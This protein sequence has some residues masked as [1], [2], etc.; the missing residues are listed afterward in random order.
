MFL[1]LVKYKMSQTFNSDIICDNCFSDS[2][3][4]YDHSQGIVV[5]ENCGFISVN[6]FIEQ[7]PE[8]RVYS[9]ENS[10]SNINPIR[11]GG[12]YNENL[13]PCGG[14]GVH[15]ESKAP[16]KNIQTI[17]HYTLTSTDRQENTHDKWVKQITAW[18]QVFR[19]QD[20]VITLAIE[21]FE[22][23]SKTERKQGK[24]VAAMSLLW[25]S[26]KKKCL[27]L[28]DIFED[29]T[30]VKPKI[31]WKM[32][33][34]IKK[35]RIHQ[36]IKTK[37]NN[38]NDAE[39]KKQ[40]DDGTKEWVPTTTKPSVYAVNFGNALNLEA[41]LVKKIELFAIKVE[42]SEVL[43]GKNP[44]TVAGVAMIAIGN[45]RLQID[46]ISSVSGISI[47]T[48]KQSCKHLILNLKELR[49]DKE[50]ENII[51]DSLSWWSKR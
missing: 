15:L 8:Y 18:G 51:A 31:S 47:P 12:T 24:K 38:D 2:H 20:R 13:S 42:N 30:G 29:V 44:K 34:S 33:K 7:T 28:G 35:R 22:D 40:S 16:S 4:R 32:E 10:S 17:T 5:C 36:E 41:P 14:L 19:L 27:L 50:E 46:G 26:R 43:T 25:A 49:L 37:Q 21:R 48:I 3:M 39:E 9:P 11:V 23:I 1:V 6:R 45:G